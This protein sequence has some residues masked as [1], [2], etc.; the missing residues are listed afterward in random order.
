[1]ALWRKLDLLWEKRQRL[2][3]DRGWG[4]R[5]RRGRGGGAGSKGRAGAGEEKE[6]KGGEEGEYA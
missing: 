5:K 4:E 2:S 6:G 1:M 3:D